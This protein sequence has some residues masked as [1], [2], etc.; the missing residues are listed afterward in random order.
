MDERLKQQLTFLIEID[1]LKSVKRETLIINGKRREN[2]AEHSWHL[3][4][5]VLIL[6]E[7]SNSDIDV[8][9]VLKMVLIHD[10]IEIYTGDC[11][12]YDEKARA[13]KAERETEAAKKIFSL[14][15]EDQRKE[16]MSLWV[17]FEKQETPEAKFAFTCDRFQPFIHNMQTDGRVWKEHDINSTKVLKNNKYLRKTSTKLWNYV[18]K[19]IERAIKKNYIVR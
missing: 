16:F 5:Y 17:E 15:P 3:A 4:L 8:L 11:F 14:L 18:K 7:H 12:L 19:A 9:I 6:K 2:V 1:K 10:L 13:G